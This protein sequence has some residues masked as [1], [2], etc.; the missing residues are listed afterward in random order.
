[1]GKEIE[2]KFLLKNDDWRLNAVGTPYRQGYLS[3]EKKATVRIR[4]QGNAAVITIKG[5]AKGMTRDEF[6]Y[7]IPVADALE[8]FELCEKPLIEKIRYKV[9]HENFTW[10]IDVFDG[11]NKGL[12]LAEIELSNENQFVNYPDWLGKEVTGDSKYYN[13]SLVHYPYCKW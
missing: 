6:E 3:S 12:I 8:L 11:E 1:M 2:R 9:K 5:P 7:N 4:V 10:E 13:F